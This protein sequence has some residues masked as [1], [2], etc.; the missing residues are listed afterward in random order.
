MLSLPRHPPTLPRRPPPNPSPAPRPR[1]RDAQ[2]TPN[3]VRSPIISTRAPIKP[4]PHH[5]QNTSFPTPERPIHLSLT[6]RSPSNSCMKFQTPNSPL[7]TKTARFDPKIDVSSLPAH[8][9]RTK[10]PPQNGFQVS[11]LKT[12]RQLEFPAAPDVVSIMGTFE[13]TPHPITTIPHSAASTPAAL[14][15]VAATGRFRQ[16]AVPESLG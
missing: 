5:F 4:P 16:I 14:Q 11:Y 2:T 9:R 1:G 6:P 7:I 12:H 8:R 10:T 3:L 15:S 13:A